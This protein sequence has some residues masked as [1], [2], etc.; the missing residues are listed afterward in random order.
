MCLNS[1]TDRRTIFLGGIDYESML[2]HY[3]KQR[4]NVDEM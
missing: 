3:S 2:K 1:I 4:L